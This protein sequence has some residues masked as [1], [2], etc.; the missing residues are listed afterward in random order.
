MRPTMD[1]GLRDT[2]KKSLVTCSSEVF[3]SLSY[4]PNLGGVRRRTA[5][6]R[7]SDEL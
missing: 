4:G 1:A 2:E 3:K 6:E 5:T 7:T